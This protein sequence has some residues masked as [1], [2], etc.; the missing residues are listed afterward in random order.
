[1]YFF[2]VGQGV[3]NNDDL[4]AAMDELNPEQVR[5]SQRLGQSSP[6][7]QAFKRIRDNTTGLTEA[8]QRILDGV[9]INAK[10]SGADLEV[11]TNTGCASANMTQGPK[12]Y[13]I[14]NKD[15][16]SEGLFQR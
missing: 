9:I 10:L 7:Y 15:S 6:L 12:P 11:C 1:M 3:K 14:R 5:V 13:C 16:Q 4:R 2:D 8:Q